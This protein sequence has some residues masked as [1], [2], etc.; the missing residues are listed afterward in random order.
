MPG[1]DLNYIFLT[2]L[3]C[4]QPEPPVL[5]S[6]PVTPYSFSINLGQGKEKLNLHF[7]PRFNE[8]AII[9]NTLDGSSWGQEYRDKHMCFSP[10]SEV[11]VRSKGS[12]TMALQ[13][14]PGD[15]SQAPLTR[16][17]PLQLTINFQEKDFKVTMPDG[18]VLTFPNRLGHSHLH[19]LS[20]DGLQISS[21]KLE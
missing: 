18:H 20:M 9:C 6:L 5:S 7:N 13:P 1:T 14:Q 3:A 15:P 8:S 16:F 21:F 11:K 2:L 10:G 19:Y 12:P 4:G 17:L